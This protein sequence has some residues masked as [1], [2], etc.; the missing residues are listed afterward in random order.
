MIG[1]AERVLADAL[2]LPP[3][4]RASIA[5]NLILSL[6]RSQDSDAEAAWAGEIDRRLDNFEASKREA[7]SWDEV[8]RR[9]KKARRAQVRP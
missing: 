1:K 2:R 8:K 4:A 7:V 5:G 3:R 6:D 9:I